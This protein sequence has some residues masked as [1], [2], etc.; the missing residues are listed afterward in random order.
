M[1][2]GRNEWNSSAF[3]LFFFFPFDCPFSESSQ[4][5]NDRG[6]RQTGNRDGGKIFRKVLKAQPKEKR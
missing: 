2:A 6:V 4:R 3:F 1:G 5:K